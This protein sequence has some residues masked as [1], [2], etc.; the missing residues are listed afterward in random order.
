MKSGKLLQLGVSSIVWEVGVKVQ[1]ISETDTIRWPREFLW[2]SS[3]MTPYQC[4][5]YSR[6]LSQIY[7]PERFSSNSVYSL[8]A[9]VETVTDIWSCNALEKTA[10]K[11]DRQYVVEDREHYST[12]SDHRRNRPTTMR[13]LITQFGQ[14]WEHTKGMWRL[15]SVWRE[16]DR[17]LITFLDDLTLDS[18]SEP[19]LEWKTCNALV[20]EIY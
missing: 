13:I 9:A 7:L 6:G 10:Q 4:T 14:S 2:K 12:R 5:R 16:A 15:G 18:K 3:S 8:E 17:M 19:T 11:V 20:A 1:S